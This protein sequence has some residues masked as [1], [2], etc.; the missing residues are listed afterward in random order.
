MAQIR[1]VDQLSQLVDKPWADPGGYEIYFI[2]ADGGTM[3][4]ESLKSQWA[5]VEEATETPGLDPQWEIVG[6]DVNWESTDL[7]DCHSY[8]IIK[9]Q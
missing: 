4:A 7:V 1:D 6:Y 3:L 9:P 2:A 5:E 8:E